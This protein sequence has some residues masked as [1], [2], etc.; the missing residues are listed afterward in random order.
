MLRKGNEARAAAAA[1]GTVRTAA[2][3]SKNAA[4]GSNPRTVQQILRAMPP[5]MPLDSVETNQVTRAANAVH[6]VTGAGYGN[7]TFQERRAAL[8]GMVSGKLSFKQAADP[9]GIYGVPS[10]TLQRDIVQLGEGKTNKELK[11]QYKSSP[12]EQ[13]RMEGL[14]QGM[15]FQSSGPRKY[16]SDTEAGLLTSISDLTTRGG[17]GSTRRD[18]ASTAREIV[19]AKGREMM[20]IAKNDTERTAAQRFMDAP[21]TTKYARHMSITQAAPMAEEG[22]TN[23]FRKASNI[24]HARAAAMN[25]LLDGVMRAKIKV[26]FDRLHAE[27]ILA[28]PTP[29]PFRVHGA[30]EVGID[31]LGTWGEFFSLGSH[32]ADERHFRT[33]AGERSPFWV[34]LILNTSAVGTMPVSPTVIHEGGSETNIPASFFVNLPVDQSW[35]VFASASGYCNPLSWLGFA[36]SFVTQT[37]ATPTNPMFLYVDGYEAHWDT[38]ALQYFLDHGVYVIFLRSHSS[39]TTQ[40][41]DNGINEVWKVCYGLCMHQWRES[42]P[43]IPLSK[44]YVNSIIADAYAMMLARPNVQHVIVEE[45]QDHQSSVQS[46]PTC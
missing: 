21:V 13:S 2:V 23:S 8:L 25:P 4:N 7:Y 12:E 27:G 46:L 19:H 39:I 32:D 41:N 42:H 9:M 24:S 37:G 10:T 1:Y 14:I 11:A 30:D 15:Q 33:V 36:V 26:L 43:G 16:L 34:S 18:M 44:P 20:E 31:V 35:Q 6:G 40:A 22:T 45:L 5:N 28:H 38:D 29:E 17:Q 3:S